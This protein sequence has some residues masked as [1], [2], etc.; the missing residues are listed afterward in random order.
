MISLTAR[1]GSPF[2]AMDEEMEQGA[3]R[4]LYQGVMSGAISG[5][6]AA[7]QMQKLKERMSK[8]RSELG[9]LGSVYGSDRN[10][11]GTTTFNNGT[12]SY[13]QQYQSGLAPYATPTYPT[14][15]YSPSLYSS[16]LAASKFTA[17]RFPAMGSSMGG[18]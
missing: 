8:T 13:G 18:Y 16:P 7:S 2:S 17:P 11:G 15:S 5:S 6:Q 10:L 12:F 9:S 14:T 1:F 3:L 4:S